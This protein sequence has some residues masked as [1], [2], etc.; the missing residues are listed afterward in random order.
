MGTTR[1]G[2]GV[3]GVGVGATG[4]LVGALLGAI[5]GSFGLI[6]DGVVDVWKL[7]FKLTYSS[8]KAKVLIAHRILACCFSI[9]GSSGIFAKI[10]LLKSLSQFFC[11]IKI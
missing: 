4:A 9:S 11:R 2:V 5:G 1:V 8:T 6:R 7:S 3:T 10:R